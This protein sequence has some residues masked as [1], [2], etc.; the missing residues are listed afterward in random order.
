[1]REMNGPEF[2]GFAGKSLGIDYAFCVG[3]HANF[4]E[5]IRD[6]PRLLSQ[7]VVAVPADKL[8]VGSPLRYVRVDFVLV[9]SEITGP[10]CVRSPAR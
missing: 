5:P 4:S 2:G 3:R 9:K 6:G 7:A 1:M 8:N 10:H